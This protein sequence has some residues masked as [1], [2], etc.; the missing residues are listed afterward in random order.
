MVGCQSVGVLAPSLRT[1][2][3][4]LARLCV[5]GDYRG[6]LATACMAH[7]ARTPGR[8]VS[9][10]LYDPTWLNLVRTGVR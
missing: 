2:F 8:E 7:S 1:V 5:D 10:V 3:G 6:K 4:S 9:L